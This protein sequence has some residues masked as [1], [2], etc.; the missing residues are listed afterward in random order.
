MSI[1]PPPAL[2]FERLEAPLTP[3]ERLPR[4][5]WLWSL[6]H[7]LG[8]LE[9]RL[10]CIEMLRGALLAGRCRGCRGRA[11]R[12]PRRSPKSSSNSSCTATAPS[13]SSA[14]PCCAR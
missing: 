12:S 9:A 1:A 2:M 8:T 4:T 7:S 10:P 11:M 13:S 14:T 3:L 6:V 5:L